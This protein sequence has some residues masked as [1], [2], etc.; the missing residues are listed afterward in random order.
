MVEQ[1]SLAGGFAHTDWWTPGFGAFRRLVR[2]RG[3]RR[4]QLS[5]L[6]E[7]YALDLRHVRFG[8]LPE[9]P[10]AT[11]SHVEQ[12]LGLRRRLSAFS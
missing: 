8:T 5:R 2:D 11:I 1:R 10:R 12:V 6:Y 9:P 4:I 7:G 3:L